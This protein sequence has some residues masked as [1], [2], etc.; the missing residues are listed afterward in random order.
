MTCKHAI[1]ALGALAALVSADLGHALQVSS[2]APRPLAPEHAELTELPALTLGPDGRRL[3]AYFTADQKLVLRDLDGGTVQTVYQTPRGPN[4]P[5]RAAV[6]AD[7]NQVHVLLRPKLGGAKSV[8][9]RTSHDGG[10]T[11][12]APVRLDTR[13]QPLLPIYFAKGDDGLLA[14]M[15]LD[16]RKATRVYDLYVNVSADGGKTFLPK[17]VRVSEGYTVSASSTFLVRGREVWAFFMGATPHRGFV[18]A[19]RSDDFGKTWQDQQVAELAERGGPMAA[20]ATAGKV[21]VF[22]ATGPSSLRGAVTSDGKTWKPLSLPA[23]TRPFDIGTIDVAAGPAGQVTVAFFGRRDGATRTTIHTIHSPDGGD[24]WEAMKSPAANPHAELTNAVAPRLVAHEDGTMVIAWH[25]YRAIRSGVYLNYSRDFGRNWQPD[26]V[27]VD[28]PGRFADS[29]PQILRG[30][31]GRY[32][33]AFLREDNDRG[34]RGKVFLSEVSL[35]PAAVTEQVDEPTRLEKLK[36]RVDSFWRGMIEDQ[37]SRNY[38]MLD[39]WFRAR[40]TRS[41][42]MSTRGGL[43]YHEAQLANV[44]LKGT[45]AD[46]KVRVSL[47]M[48]EVEVLGKRHSMPKHTRFIEERWLWVAD[49]WYREVRDATTN[50]GLTPY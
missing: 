39:P 5:S 18:I 6:L 25:D 48:P 50:T 20:V 7:G 21:L 42:Y 27:A 45:I 35:P 10:K 33:L 43:V 1:A 3:V 24:T 30:R 8:E 38:E 12:A 4:R 15:W 31:D 47:E 36:E 16:E 40:V 9:V 13:G 44:D 17:D 14:A 11:F 26:V 41:G 49:N 32:T 28:Q 22:W 29:F 34:D 37:W 23:E 46:V 19:S 2:T